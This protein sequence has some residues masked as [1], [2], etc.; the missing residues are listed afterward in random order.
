MTSVTASLGRAVVLHLAIVALVMEQSEA[1]LVPSTAP[2]L[3]KRARMDPNGSEKTTMI[4][5]AMLGFFGLLAF[6]LHKW[7]HCCGKHVAKNS[8]ARATTGHLSHREGP[9]EN[10]RERSVERSTR[11]RAREESDVEASP[12]YRR[13]PPLP[14]AASPVSPLDLGHRDQSRHAG[15]A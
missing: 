12:Q 13:H 15:A 14:R 4:I 5:L 8:D 2:S 7:G 3:A 9:R 6:A 10:A 1:T 11:S